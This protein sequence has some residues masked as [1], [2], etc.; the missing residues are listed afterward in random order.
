MPNFRKISEVDDGEKP[1]V[2]TYDDWSERDTEVWLRDYTDD[3]GYDEFY[4][5]VGHRGYE[6]VR[7][8]LEKYGGEPFAMKI[9]KIKMR[10]RK[11]KD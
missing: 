2:K 5:D 8:E 1:P 11:C 3:Y 6:V 4:S 10:V 9:G 7:D